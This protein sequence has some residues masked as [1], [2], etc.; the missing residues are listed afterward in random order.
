L[1]F[2]P[3]ITRNVK[4]PYRANP[5]ELGMRADPERESIVKNGQNGN[6]DRASQHSLSRFGSSPYPGVSH[7]M[8]ARE[9]GGA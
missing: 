8:V 5:L 4:W 7:G 3:P 2:L 6:V 1:P 9:H